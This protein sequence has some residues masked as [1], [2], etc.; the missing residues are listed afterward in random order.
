MWTSIVD[1]GNNNYYNNIAKCNSHQ[2]F[3]GGNPSGRF[4]NGKVPSDLFGILQRARHLNK[5]IFLRI[6]LPNTMFHVMHWNLIT[7][8][9]FKFIWYYAVEDLGKD[10]KMSFAEK[11]INCDFT[12]L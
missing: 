7:T 3:M 8:Y 2:D 11:W 6:R 5:T 4:S 9:K 1:T 10:L 12:N